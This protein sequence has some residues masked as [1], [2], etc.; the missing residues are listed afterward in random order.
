MALEILKQGTALYFDRVTTSASGAVFGS[1]LGLLLFSYVVARLVLLVTAWAA[2]APGNERPVPLAPPAPAVLTHVVVRSGPA[3]GT[4][5]AV[6]AAVV[7]GV[8]VGA[9]LS[10]TARRWPVRGRKDRAAV[11]PRRSSCVGGWATSAARSS[12]GSCSTIPNG[13]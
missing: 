11:D 8:L 5:G 1:L 12:R 6:G 7:T 9:W 3:G 13:R 4:A 2:T 10:G